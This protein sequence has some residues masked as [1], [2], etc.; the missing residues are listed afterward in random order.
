[1]MDTNAT[2]S[3]AV[4]LAQMARIEEIRAERCL[5]NGDDASAADAF[6]LSEAA[7]ELLNLIME[8]V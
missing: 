1:M 5:A 2:Y 7:D 3:V 8:R 6:R 4:T